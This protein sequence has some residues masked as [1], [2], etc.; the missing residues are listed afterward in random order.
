MYPAVAQSAPGIPAIF[1]PTNVAEFTAI[2][3]G[4]ICEIVTRSPNSDTDSQ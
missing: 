2:G 1:S 3:P 4:V